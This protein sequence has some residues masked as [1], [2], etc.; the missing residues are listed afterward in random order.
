MLSN[1][2]PRQIAYLAL[3]ALGLLATWYFNLAFMAESGGSFDVADFVAAGYANNA[4]ASLSNDLLIGTISFLV[5]SFHETRRLGLRHWWA[6][7]VLTFAVAFAVA[8]PLF[9]FVRDRHLS[10]QGS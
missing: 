9:L 4:S 2:T 5:W 7:V 1:L 6:Y 3:S 10:Q 8:F